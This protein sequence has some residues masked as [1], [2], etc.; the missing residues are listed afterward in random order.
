MPHL[1]VL[2]THNRKKGLELVELVQP[3]GCEVKTLADFPAAIEV[4]EDGGTFAINAALKA[5]QQAVHL[6][7]WVLAEDSGLAVDGL[8]GRPG[9][10]SARYA[11][12]KA[13]DQE[14]NDKLLEE[15][16]DLPLEKRTAHYVCHATL[17]DPTGQVRTEAEDTC[18][19]RILF[20]AQGSHG[21]GYD[22]VF[23]ILEYHRTFGQLGPAV[24]GLLSHRSRALRRLVPELARLIATSQW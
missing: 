19:G 9:V 2:G 8:G 16:G 15:L 22:P 21:F 6:G 7:Q 12:D 23:E 24:K 1:L 17:A 13:T 10:Y 5:T 14:N 20:H 18:G 4:V 3:L 11:G